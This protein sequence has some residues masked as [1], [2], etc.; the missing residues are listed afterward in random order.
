[1]AAKTSAKRTTRKTT[2]KKTTQKTTAARSTTDESNEPSPVGQK[3]CAY[4]SC[5]QRATQEFGDNKVPSCD[6]H[7]EV[8]Q[9]QADDGAGI[10]HLMEN[11]RG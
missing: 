10:Q 5:S 11:Y 8:F 7:A 6:I 4:P 2:A 3:S 9:T 1:M